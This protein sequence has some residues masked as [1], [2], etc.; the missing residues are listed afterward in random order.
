LDIAK[1][2]K[3]HY[4]AVIFNSVLK[5]KADG[6]KSTADRMVELAQQQPG[7]LGFESARNEIGI[8]ISYWEDLDSI[9]N[10]K[11]NTE[12]LLAQ[13]R[14]KEKWYKSYA[15]RICKVEKQYYFDVE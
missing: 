5:E 4:Y 10:W 13:K 2:N 9:K 15:L 12:H 6:Y 3:T 11:E 1:I 14:G 7:F 8:T